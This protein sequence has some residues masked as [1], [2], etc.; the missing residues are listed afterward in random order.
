MRILIG[1]AAFALPFVAVVAGQ[2]SSSGLI[3]VL[4]DQVAGVLMG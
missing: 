3:A 1:L 2:G 4:V